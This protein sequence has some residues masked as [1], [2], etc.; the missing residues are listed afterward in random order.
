[1]IKEMNTWTRNDII[2]WQNEKLLKLTEHAYKNTIYYR[3][4]FNK[5]NIV[6]SDINNLQDLKIL[7]VLTKH[8]IITNWNDI[9][10]KNLINYRY[11]KA[12]TG[13]S[14]GNPLK[15]LLDI[16]T[17]SYISAARIYY[18]E[19]VGYNLGDKHIALGS[20]SLFPIN[21][22]SIKHDIYYFLKGKIPLNG[23]NMSDAV[24]ENYLN[25]IKKFKIEII[26][27]YASSL[28][29]ISKYVIEKQIENLPIKVCISTSEILT[30]HYRNTIQDAFGCKILDA[31]G[32]ADGGVTAY[33]ISDFFE[34]GYNCFINFNENYSGHSPIFLTDLFNYSFPFIR[35]EVGDEVEPVSKYSSA[36]YKGQIFKKIIGRISEIMRL[37][38]GRVLTGPGFTILFKDLDIKAYRIKKDK[39]LSIVCE[40]IPLKNFTKD[41][42][43][44]IYNTLKKHSGLECDVKIEIKNNFEETASGKRNYFIA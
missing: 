23:I 39:P 31:Y 21:K 6:P 3:K 18:W 36:E 7:P 37:E 27:G 13:G 5:F 2:K 40:V 24:I 4:V 15:Y 22:K 32:A 9:V 19:K 20:S 38:N 43:D 8:D 12:S 11:K 25:I 1:M 10:P 44:L 14:T 41:Q 35:Y 29:L 28:F 33:L 26:Y 17:W 34:V 30:D 16:E 42:S